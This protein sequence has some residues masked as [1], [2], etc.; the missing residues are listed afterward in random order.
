MQF[1]DLKFKIHPEG[2]VG[3]HVQFENVTVSIQ[4]GRL[5]YSI[6]RMDNID[7]TQYSKFE[8]AV[9]ENNNKRKHRYVTHKYLDTEDMVAGWT[10]KEQINK[11]L[12]TLSK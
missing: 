5:Y 10:S 11:L 7:S 6:P 3:T 1:K 8:V 12:K 4:A 9:W 2:G